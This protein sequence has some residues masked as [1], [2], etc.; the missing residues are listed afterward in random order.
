MLS[1]AICEDDPVQIQ[2]LLNL[3]TKYQELRPDLEVV[4]ENFASGGELLDSLEARHFYDI[5]LLDILMPELNGIDLARELRLRG[6]EAPLIFLTSSAD[7]A[8]D[9]FDVNATQYLLKPVKEDKLFSILNKLVSSLDKEEERFLFV[10]TPERIVKI[11]LSSIICVESI[12]RTIQVYLVDG[13]KI[14]SKTIRVPFASVID[15]LFQDS[16]F[17]YAHKS[18]VLN[19]AQVNELTGSSFIM[20]NGI[21]V[22]IPR[23]RYTDAK[24]T[25]LDYISKRSLNPAEGK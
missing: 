1:V 17:L 8:L 9:A 13:R 11:P 18:F 20:K 14:S 19:M 2:A 7:Y 25:Y 6:E 4:T 23:Y 10:S 24:A 12:W 21:E 22:P 3:M 15:V 5:F 16:R